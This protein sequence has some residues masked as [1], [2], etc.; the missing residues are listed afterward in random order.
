MHHRRQDRT[1]EVLHVLKRGEFA[2]LL[3]CWLE[4]VS[5]DCNPAHDVALAL[6]GEGLVDLCKRVKGFVRLVALPE[7]LEGSGV[8]RWQS[9]RLGPPRRRVARASV[10]RAVK[11]D[12]LQPW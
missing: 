8:K 5:V 1:S 10:L 9:R 6:C 3:L 4:A 2:V 7:S 12:E 11:L